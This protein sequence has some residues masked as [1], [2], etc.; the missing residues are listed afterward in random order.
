MAYCRYETNPVDPSE[1]EYA[2]VSW[3][4]RL[5]GDEPICFLEL[6][7]SLDE[8]LIVR[9]ENIFPEA[10]MYV[11]DENSPSHSFRDSLNKPVSIREPN[12]GTVFKTGRI[13]KSA[14]GRSQP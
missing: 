12:V 9:L 13:E 1:Y 7:S 3:V 4:R 5:L 14:D 10:R 11:F 6:S 8:Q 2:R